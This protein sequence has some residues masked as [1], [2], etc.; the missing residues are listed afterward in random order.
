MRHVWRL[1]SLL[2]CENTALCYNEIHCMK[3][4][5]SHEDR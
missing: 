5:I 1:E 3:E 4:D 2:F